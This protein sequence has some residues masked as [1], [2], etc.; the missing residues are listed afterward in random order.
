MP[1]RIASARAS[2]QMT[3]LQCVCSMPVQQDLDEM[4]MLDD[5]PR[6]NNRP[7]GYYW[8]RSACVEHHWIND[9]S[10]I[11]WTGLDPYADARHRWRCDVQARVPAATMTACIRVFASQAKRVGG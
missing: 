4:D 1:H 6:I 7:R 10:N 9:E 8:D 3:C 11:V 5:T 2:M